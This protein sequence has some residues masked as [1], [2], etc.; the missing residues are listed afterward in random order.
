MMKKKWLTIAAIV[1]V[2]AAGGGIAAYQSLTGNHVEIQEVI[3]EGATEAA[4]GAVV[5]SDQLNGEWNI[6]DGSE[7]YLSMTTSKETVNMTVGAVQGKWLIDT[8]NAA[9]ITAEGTVDVNGLDSG[10]SMRDGHIKGADYLNAEAFP[11]ATFTA[12]SVEGLPES[13]SE[14]VAVPIKLN[15]TL[16]VRGVAKDVVFDSQAVYEQGQVKLAGNTIVTFADFGMANPHQV[17]VET[18]NNVKVELQLIL[19]KQAV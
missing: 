19:D 17:V 15:G 10:N 13:W 6:S 16:T 3:A 5:T 11:Q 1:V 14:G 7:V 8:A 12:T 9:Q 4:S 2:V 18:E